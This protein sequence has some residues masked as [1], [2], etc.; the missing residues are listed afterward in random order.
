V[1][2]KLHENRTPEFRLRIRL[3]SLPKPGELD[4]FSLE[5]YHVGQI[6]VLPSQ[7]ATLLIL[8]GHAEL[9]GQS[10]VRAEAADFRPRFPKK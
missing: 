10:Q 6:Y 1:T 8:S 9:V 5:H 3:I 2:D 7:L 4:D